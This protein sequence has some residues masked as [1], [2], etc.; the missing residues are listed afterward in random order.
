[1]IKICQHFFFVYQ[2]AR[3]RLQDRVKARG[4]WSGGKGASGSKG[5]KGKGK[6]KGF[7]G[8]KGFRSLQQ[9]IAESYC[10]HCNQKGHWRAECPVRK[11]AESQGSGSEK[12]AYVAPTSAAVSFDLDQVPEISFENNE[13]PEDTDVCVFGLVEQRVK[14]FEEKFKTKLRAKPQSPVRKSRDACLPEVSAQ[15]RQSKSDSIEEL[16]SLFASVGTTGVVDLGASQTV[17]GSEQVSELLNNLPSE[18]QRQARKTKCN[19]IFKFGNHQTLPSK[20]A[21]LLPLQGTWIRI[22]IVEGRT[23]FLLSSSFL[24]RVQ[25]VIDT[26]KGT[27]WSK[28]LNRNLHMTQTNKNLFLLDI[29]QLWESPTS[30][31]CSEPDSVLI[32]KSS[33]QESHDGPINPDQCVKTFRAVPAEVKGREPSEGKNSCSSTSSSAVSERFPTHDMKHESQ[34]EVH[35]LL[36]LRSLPLPVTRVVSPIMSALSAQL[37]RLQ[38]HQKEEEDQVEIDEMTLADLETQVIMFGKTKMGCKFPEA[39]ADTQ[40]TRFVVSKFESS[41]KKEHRMYVRYVQL[42][43]DQMEKEELSPEDRYCLHQTTVGPT[44]SKTTER[45]G[46]MTALKSKAKPKASSASVPTYAP[47]PQGLDLAMSP[48]FPEELYDL[49]GR[50]NSVEHT[51][52]EIVHHLRTLASAPVEQPCNWTVI[53]EEHPEI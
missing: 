51:L 1:M 40:W 50:M 38:K 26:E 35:Q 8:S 7:K 45:K 41:T 44:S 22:A 18:I 4:F 37:L 17:I 12:S 39:F 9:R 49:Q 3:R 28:R 27:L 33:P 43:L 23:P 52:Q 48:S 14:F 20:V 53:K 47:D 19:L 46:P 15:A 6:G 34:L 32:V 13:H 21:L 29:N 36:A 16:P 10:R 24:K 25:A 30:K 31:Q 2:D 11:S 5:F 42:R